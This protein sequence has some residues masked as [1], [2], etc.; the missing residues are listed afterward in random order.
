MKVKSV[1]SMSHP[2]ILSRRS[3]IHELLVARG[4]E[5]RV[6]G[7]APLAVRIETEEA[8]RA[9]APTLG[10]CDVSAL[11]K[12]AIKGPDAENRL[13]DRGIEVPAEIY[14][15]C[16]LGAGGWIVRTGAEEFFLESGATDDSVSALASI[17]DSVHG[18]V[19]RIERQ[20]ATLLLVGSRASDVL[21]QTCGVNL[22]EAAAHRLVL[23]RVAGISC[24]VFPQCFADVPGYRL[25]VDFTYA[26]ALWETLVEICESLDGRVI[27]AGCLLADSSF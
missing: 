27:G 23:T 11:P 18:R 24:G 17:F 4:A 21:A 19:F 22:R 25:W 15:S 1:R 2:E 16:R 26:V 5:W 3:P 8:E 7:G 6:V 10:L 20:D 12:L 13:K 14:E 9:A